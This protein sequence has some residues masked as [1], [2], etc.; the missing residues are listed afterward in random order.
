MHEPLGDR[1]WRTL[2]S[3]SLHAVPKPCGMFPSRRSSCAC[4]GAGFRPGG[5][6]V[7][8]SEQ[9][10]LIQT[11]IESALERAVSPADG[12]NFLHQDTKLFS[13]IVQDAVFDSHR[14]GAV[15]VIGFHRKT[16]LVADRRSID[17]GLR[18]KVDREPTPQR[19]GGE[20]RKGRRGKGDI[21]ISWVARSPPLPPAPCFPDQS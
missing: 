20:R 4:S 3:V 13:L 14:Y 2:G 17:N 6:N 1:K 15:V 12:L 19:Q 5:D 21:Q 16:M 9:A 18:S 11:F 8:Q 7:F 10:W